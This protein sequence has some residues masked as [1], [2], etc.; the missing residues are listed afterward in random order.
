MRNL[1]IYVVAAALNNRGGMGTT[2]ADKLNC[3]SKILAKWNNEQFGKVG[4]SIQELKEELES[5][6]LLE[7][8]LETMAREADIVEKIDEWRLREEILWRQ[9]SRAEWL[10]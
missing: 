2:L 9:R 1:E 4:K 10:R 3:C 7:R 5:V 8:D 6:R